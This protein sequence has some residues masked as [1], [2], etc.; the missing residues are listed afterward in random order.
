MNMPSLSE[1]AHGLSIENATVRFGGLVAVDDVSLSAAPRDIT[2]LIGP[3]GAGKTTLFNVCSGYQRPTAGRVTLDGRDVTHASPAARARFGLGRTFQRTEL[4][5]SLTVRENLAWA[6]ESHYVGVDP[7][8]QLGLRR[9]GWKRRRDM[10][11]RTDRALFD[12]GL[13]PIADRQ[14][15]QLSTG[16]A[17]VLEL[18]RA[19]VREPSVLLLDEPSS[20][21][22]QA[23]SAVF[24]QRLVDV[25][26]AQHIAIL[27]VEH[28]MDL[29]LDISRRIY[30]LDFG[31]LL[32]SGTPDDVRNSEDVRAA[33]LGVN[34][35]T[36]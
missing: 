28:D 15:S 9:S 21:L 31:K 11:Q 36:S 3:N 4:F 1:A 35:A 22:D 16:Q 23:E 10:R 26:A 20:G 2:A 27:M 34:T 25:V 5:A 30:V 13:E 6:V 7:L 24:G 33:Y 29:V 14:A 17:R 12:A 32:M 19:L 18:E 8:S